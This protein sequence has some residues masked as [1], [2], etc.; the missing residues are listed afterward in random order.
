MA[1]IKRHNPDI[2]YVGPS[3]YRAFGYHQS[4]SWMGMIHYAGIAP[5]SGDDPATVSCVG[6]RDMKAQLDYILDILDQCMAAD[7][8]DRSRILSWTMYVT[9]VPAFMA[10]LPTLTDWMGEH[11]PAATLVAVAGLA[12][13]DQMIEITAFAAG[14]DA[15][16]DR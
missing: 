7:G 8:I 9:E 12:H 14:A 13:P 16:P 10:V 6:P 3:V 11:A 15:A 1:A 2:A 5:L 4:V